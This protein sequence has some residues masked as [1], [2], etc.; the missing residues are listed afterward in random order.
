MVD[1]QPIGRSSYIELPRD[2][3]DTKASDIMGVLAQKTR[4]S[5]IW[6]YRGKYSVLIG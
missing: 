4:Y 1:Y 5:H 3:Y 2:I 6:S